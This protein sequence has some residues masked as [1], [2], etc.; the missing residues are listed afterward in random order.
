MLPSAEDLGDVIA[1]EFDVNPAG[2]RPQRAVD[3][4][5]AAELVHDGVETA[6]L[7]A[8]VGGDG[9]AVH[10]IGDPGDRA[11]V[12]RDGFDECG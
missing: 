3:L 7:V 1:G 2:H 9:V 8:I 4:E 10:G 11:A 5:E 12:C 6:G